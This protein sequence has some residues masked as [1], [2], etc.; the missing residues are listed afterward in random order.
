MTAYGIFDKRFALIATNT[1]SCIYVNNAYIL[2][3]K[4]QIVSN[5]A[6]IYKS[7]LVIYIDVYVCEYLRMDENS[8]VNGILLFAEQSENKKKNINDIKY[9]RNNHIKI[10]TATILESQIVTSFKRRTLTYTHICKPIQCTRT[11][12]TRH[13][14]ENRESIIEGLESAHKIWI[15]N[16]I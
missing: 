9:N 4:Y 1:N 11:E 5:S 15:E 8:L 14:I 13:F 16:Y 2:Y 7:I 3:T 12:T 6:S 10:T